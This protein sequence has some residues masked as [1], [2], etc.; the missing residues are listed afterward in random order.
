M[1]V[2]QPNLLEEDSDDSSSS[3]EESD[4]DLAEALERMER[5]SAEEEAKSATTLNPPDS[6]TGTWSGGRTAA[7][8]RGWTITWHRSWFASWRDSRRGSR[9]QSWV[10]SFRTKKFERRRMN[11]M[12]HRTSKSFG[13][14][15]SKFYE[16]MVF[17]RVMSYP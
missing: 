7:W 13:W 11:V 9:S 2:N 14:H 3:D 15:T 17:E 6:W 16:S 12:H 4:E 1:H 8:C 10:G 5:A